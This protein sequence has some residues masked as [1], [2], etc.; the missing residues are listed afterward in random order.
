M[1]SLLLPMFATAMATSCVPTCRTGLLNRDSEI[2]PL[3]E[4]GCSGDPEMGDTRGCE[5][6]RGGGVHVLSSSRILSTVRMLLCTLMLS[7]Q[8]AALSGFVQRGM[9]GSTEADG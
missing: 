8:A 5:P 4:L 1:A 2:R 6:S 3:A 7:V 9:A